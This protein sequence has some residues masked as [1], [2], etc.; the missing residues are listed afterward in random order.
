[1][2]E[3]SKV[4]TLWQKYRAQFAGSVI[5]A[6]L[7]I[8]SYPKFNVSLLAF[9]AFAPMLF[10]LHSNSRLQK[11]FWCWF[12]GF[13]FYCAILYWIVPTCITGGLNAVLAVL[14]LLLLSAIIALSWAAFGLLCSFIKTKNILWRAVLISCAWVSA[15]WLF[16]LLAQYGCWFPWF[17]L[18]YTQWKFTLLIQIANITGTAGISFAVI[19]FGLCTGLFLQ[20]QKT[21]KDFARLLGLPIIL[22][23]LFCIYGLAYKSLTGTKNAAEVSVYL[24]QPNINQ[25]KKWNSKF[26]AEIENTLTQMLKTTAEK[27]PDLI[28]WP[29]SSFPRNLEYYALLFKSAETY[30]AVGGYSKNDDKHVSLYAIDPGAD[31]TAVYHKRV[32]VPFGEYVPLKNA[33]GKHIGVLNQ[34]GSFTK[35]KNNQQSFYMRDRNTG[36]HIILGPTICYE[37]IFPFLW[38]AHAKNNAA[39]FI[40]STNDGWYLNTAAPYQHFAATALRAAEFSIPVAR[41]TNTGISGFFNRYG[42]VTGKTAL[43]QQATAGQT[44]YAQNV[45]TIY[46]RT[47]NLFSFLCLLFL[48]LTSLRI[49]KL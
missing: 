24:M 48:A 14:A 3:E 20:S 46:T 44:V 40:N 6:L 23:A 35:G 32:L 10:V 28:I 4:K 22:A 42:K 5:T 2:T 25:Y 30:Q 26:V 11:V 38:R 9:I 36:E 41:A 7:L 13:L 19:F 21:K 39:L 16:M 31:I 33:L 12:A 18:G 47:G 49:I 45:K 8:L 43:N 29:E 15:E 27:K 17:M 37:T 34:M 1:M